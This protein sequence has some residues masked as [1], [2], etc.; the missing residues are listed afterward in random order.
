M[1]ATNRDRK[2]MGAGH[3]ALLHYRQ[4]AGFFVALHQINAFFAII[5][6]TVN[7]GDG[8]QRKRVVVI[9]C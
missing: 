3:F 2:G 4:L 1:T 5:C 8:W 7:I 6:R 9:S